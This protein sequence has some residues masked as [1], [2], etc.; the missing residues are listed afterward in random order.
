MKFV[1]YLGSIFVLTFALSSLGVNAANYLVMNEVTVPLNRGEHVEIAGKDEV[2]GQYVKYK[3]ATK[4]DSTINR[5]IEA[6][7]MG[8]D[9]SNNTCHTGYVTLGK[10]VWRPIDYSLIDGCGSTPVNGQAFLKLRT[11]NNYS[12]T[13]FFWGSW[14]TTT[15]AYNQYKNSI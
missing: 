14:I 12:D 8:K 13:T 6:R 10:D 4:A 1:K 11:L 3:R 15:T 7:L 9:V 2:S 5:T